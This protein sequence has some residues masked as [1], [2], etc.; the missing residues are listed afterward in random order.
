MLDQPTT[1]EGQCSCSRSFAPARSVALGHSRFS[2][3]PGYAK[4]VYNLNPC[5]GFFASRRAFLAPDR[6]AVESGSARVGNLNKFFLPPSGAERSGIV[7]SDLLPPSA[8][9]VGDRLY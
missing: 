8:V 4:V 6:S 2:P 7:G 9:V 3:P 1:K 5:K